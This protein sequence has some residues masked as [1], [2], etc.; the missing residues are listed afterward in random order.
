MVINCRTPLEMGSVPFSQGSLLRSLGVKLVDIPLGGNEGF[1]PQ[2]VKA[3][4]EALA[5]HTGGKVLIH[6]AGGGHGA[7][8]WP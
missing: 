7:P 4:K 1:E 3:L 2:D 5:N 6:C 8:V